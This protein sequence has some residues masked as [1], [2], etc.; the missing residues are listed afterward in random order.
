MYSFLRWHLD[1]T[2]LLSFN[3]SRRDKNDDPPL[4]KDASYK[5]RSPRFYK[6]NGNLFSWLFSVLY[7]IQNCQ[8]G[9]CYKLSARIIPIITPFHLK[10]KIYFLWCIYICILWY[11]MHVLLHD[12]HWCFNAYENSFCTYA[13]IALWNSM[14]KTAACTYKR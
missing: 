10:R 4:T 13:I 12:N 1:K 7:I 8:N 3:N 6:K 9:F 5:K 11:I 2:I 14:R